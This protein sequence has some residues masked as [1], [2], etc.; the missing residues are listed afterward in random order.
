MKKFIHSVAW[1]LFVL[2]L[3]AFSGCSAF[4][5][6]K[7]VQVVKSFPKDNAP[8]Q[9]I[10]TEAQ[11]VILKNIYGGQDFTIS[12]SENLDCFNDVYTVNDV[13]IWY[14]EAND[15]AVV[16][17]EKT[18]QFNTF[19]IHTFET[20]ETDTILQVPLEAGFQPQ[21]IGIFLDAAYFCVID[22]E[23]QQ[24]QVLGYDIGAKKTAELYTVA[25][26]DERQPYSINLENGYLSFVCSNHVKVLNLQSNETVY[27]SPLP[28]DVAHIFGISYDSKNDTCALYY[29]DS[30][31]EDIGIMKE[32]ED[33]ILSILTFSEN[34]YAYHDKIECYDG[35]IYWIAQANITGAVTDHYTLVDYN[36]LEHKVVETDRTFDF[37]RIEN[38]LYILRFNKDGDYTHIDICQ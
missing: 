21:N 13:S 10:K 19:K 20:Q 30:D 1:M 24:V 31:S 16:W 5:P 17:C 6:Q 7:Q 38:A 11:W 22:Y 4:V 23:Q 27:D 2:F 14:F 25:F 15:K 12:V 29:A 8:S 3:T 26:Y 35:H 34:H 37:C 18:D 33:K 32:G 28:S 9:V 36:Y